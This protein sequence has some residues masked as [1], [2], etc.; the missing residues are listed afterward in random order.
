[1]LR[2]ALV[3]PGLLPTRRELYLHFAKVRTAEVSVRT[4]LNGYLFRGSLLL[5]FSHILVYN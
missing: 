4:C 5:N 3:I 2:W 1:M